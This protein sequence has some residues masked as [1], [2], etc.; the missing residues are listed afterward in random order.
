VK[1]EQRIVYSKQ[2]T[3]AELQSVKKQKEVKSKKE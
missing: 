2:I 1:E 3:G